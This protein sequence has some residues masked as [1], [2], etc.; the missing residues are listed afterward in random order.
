MMTQSARAAFNSNNASAVAAQPLPSGA[1]PFAPS[2]AVT[3]TYLRR[4]AAFP[5]VGKGMPRNPKWA[6][7][8]PAAAAALATRGP[9]A[10]ALQVHNV[11]DRAACG[12]CADVAEL[13]ADG[14]VPEVD[15]CAGY[16]ALEAVKAAPEGRC[17]RNWCAGDTSAVAEGSLKL[18]HY[19]LPRGA[20]PYR[21]GGTGDAGQRRDVWADD[22]RDADALRFAP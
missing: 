13:R 15:P 2:S 22:V 11:W 3:R 17:T 6:L 8:V 20:K 7:R 10:L 21:R 14:L 18:H 5:P 4:A 19:V 12:R 16:Y 1:S 9:H